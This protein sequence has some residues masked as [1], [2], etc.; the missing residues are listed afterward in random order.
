MS[1]RRN[2]IK[3]TDLQ[4]V[5]KLSK[6]IQNCIKNRRVKSCRECLRFKDCYGE[7]KYVW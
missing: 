7:E 3:G 5:S 2:F 1:K 6:K 4:E